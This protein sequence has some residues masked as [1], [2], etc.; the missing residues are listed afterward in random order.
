MSSWAES[1]ARSS[2]RNRIVL[3]TAS[4]DLERRMEEATDGACV[5]LPLG[6]LPTTPAAV[7]SHLG[8]APRPELIVLDAGADPA[9][10]I[11]LASLFDVQCPGITVIVV[12]P[13]AQDIGTEAMH[14]GVRAILDS[15]ADEPTIRSVLDRAYENTRSRARDQDL[16]AAAAGPAQ[17]GRVITVSSAKGGVGRTTVATNLAVGLARTGPGSTVLVDLDLQ[18]GDVACALGLDPEYALPDA[19]Q[20]LATRDTMVLKTF[21]TLH[22][23]GL[24]VICGPKTPGEGDNVPADAVSRLLE[25]LRS[26]FQYVIVDTGVGMSEHVLAALDESSDVVLVSGMDVPGVRDL[27]KELDALTR[28]GLVKDSRHVVLNFVDERAGLLVSDVEATLGVAAD[29]LLPRSL[30]ALTSVNEGVPLLQRPARREP[31][32]K[33]LQ[34]LQAKLAPEAPL[35]VGLA[36]LAGAPAAGSPARSSRRA[37][38][39]P[40]FG[41]GRGRRTASE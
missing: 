36:G 33:E 40:S 8:A 11:A 25:M 20:G 9:P 12:S 24:Y 26:E 4:P 19:V 31:V 13:A 37:A 22:R 1:W 38:P 30:A 2:P 27:R 41:W 23:T 10:A 5:S 17:P 14:A 28:L 34:K 32:T 6:P 15:E 18:F 39:A 21:L 3:A 29:F 35:S 16:L 7:F